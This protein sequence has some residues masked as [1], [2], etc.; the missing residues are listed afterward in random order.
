MRSTDGGAPVA[1]TTNTTT[2]SVT[3]DATV[4]DALVARF[5]A[6]EEARFA[7]FT[8]IGRLE[9]EAEATRAAIVE[10]QR[11]TRAAVAAAQHGREQ[12]LTA[13]T[14]RVDEA[15]AA[16]SLLAAR[17]RALAAQVQAAGALLRRACKTSHAQTAAQ[18]WHAEATRAAAATLPS[19][20]K[21]VQSSHSAFGRGDASSHRG[22]SPS[23]PRM[24]SLRADAVD[25]AA[26]EDPP[27]VNAAALAS[28]GNLLRGSPI[29]AAQHDDGNSDAPVSAS[30][31]IALASLLERR[32]Q[33]LCLDMSRVEAAAAAVAGHSGGAVMPALAD[34]AAAATSDSGARATIRTTSYSPQSGSAARSPSMPTSP[35]TTT[36]V[37]SLHHRVGP[38]SPSSRSLGS[39][40]GE[41]WPLHLPSVTDEYLR[42]PIAAVAEEAAALHGRHAEASATPASGAASVAGS[43]KTRTSKTH[44]GAA[45]QATVVAAATADA[46]PASHDTHADSPAHD[47]DEASARDP[48]AMQSPVLASLIAVNT[49]LTRNRRSS[50]ASMVDGQPTAP[51]T[52]ATTVLAMHTT[53]A[54][55][56]HPQLGTTYHTPTDAA[57]EGTASTG[58]STARSSGGGVATTV[59]SPVTARRASARLSAGQKAVPAARPASTDSAKRG[60]SSATGRAGRTSSRK[61][62]GQSAAAPSAGSETTA[63]PAG[64]APSTTSPVAASR[65]YEM[66]VAG[67]PTATQLHG[68]APTESTASGAGG[69]NAAADPLQH[70]SLLACSPTPTLVLPAKMQLA[71]TDG[72]KRDGVTMSVTAHGTAAMRTA[73]PLPKTLYSGYQPQARSPTTLSAR[74]QA[75]SCSTT[76][77][78]HDDSHTT[79][80]AHSPSL[81]TSDTDIERKHELLSSLTATGGASSVAAAAR[82]RIAMHQIASGALVLPRPA[83]R[84]SL[85]LDVQGR[86]GTLQ[87]AVDASA[88]RAAADD[89][90]DTHRGWLLD[91]QA[92]SSADRSKLAVQPN[93]A[94]IA[95]AHA[96]GGAGGG[97]GAINQGRAARRRSLERM[98]AMINSAR[99]AAQRLS[100]A[101][102]HQCVPSTRNIQHWICNLA[103]LSTLIPLPCCTCSYCRAGKRFGP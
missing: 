85:L 90:A 21:R 84:R 54:P 6:D 19:S 4:V 72:T 13:L 37:T 49:T 7:A 51:Q 102:S 43:R 36:T 22:R 55:V 9:A 103:R 79:E 52:S 53:G 70:F 1:T 60:G 16:A 44:A 3:I 20:P 69:G 99:K 58:S 47:E 30:D 32:V 76:V 77:T 61:Q 24:T 91:D 75:M 63:L 87:A 59:L 42:L 11:A 33:Q 96:T 82:H 66:W 74:N 27:V 101:E 86:M 56:I 57:E 62:L 38:R 88:A 89:A 78:P 34:G 81:A 12:E 26:A 65:E 25:A 67:L 97:T 28:S 93:A 98:E 68:A 5:L 14:S 94:V 64:P 73:S 92:T 83:D 41:F 8:E 15:E 71:A 17:E 10:V 18:E 23:L 39:K 48:A 29:T 46:S 45:V 40:L 35:L 100:A 80:R 31:C 95:S 2:G 50:L